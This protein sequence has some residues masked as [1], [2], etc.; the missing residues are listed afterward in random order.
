[1]TRAPAIVA[2][3]GPPGGDLLAFMPDPAQFAMREQRETLGHGLT[4][5]APLTIEHRAY[6]TQ[7]TNLAVFSAQ[8]LAIDQDSGVHS[9]TRFEIEAREPPRTSQ[10]WLVTDEIPWLTTA[11]D[12]DVVVRYTRALAYVNGDG[13]QLQVTVNGWLGYTASQWAGIGVWPT[14]SGSFAALLDKRANAGSS[15]VSVTA[16]GRIG[17]VTSSHITAAV[18]LRGQ[19]EEAAALLMSSLGVT[20]TLGAGPDPRTAFL[21][22]HAAVGEQHAAAAAF[23]RWVLETTEARIV[24]QLD[25][26]FPRD[27][28]R[29][30][31]LLLEEYIDGDDE[32]AII[33]IIRTWSRH[34]DVLHASGRSYFDEFLNALRQSSW[35]RDYGLFT[36]S[37]TSFYTSLFEETEEKAGEITSLIAT[38][39]R[40]FGDYVPAW[41]LEAQGRAP[42]PELTKQT[43]SRVLDA[44]KG[45]TSG[46]DEHLILQTMTGLPGPTQRAVL[47]DIMSRHD[48]RE[49]LVFGKYG[50]AWG[51]GMLYW[52]F[53]ELD[54]DDRAELSKDLVAK[55]VLD[56]NM[57]AVL[58]AGRGWGG[59]W[60]PFTTRKAQ[61]GAQ[62]FA[63]KANEGHWWAY[64]LGVACSLWLPETAGTTVATI[65]AARVLPGVARLHPYVATG[66]L[67]TGTFLSSYE[68]G[69]HAQELATGK[70]PY[71]GR[72]LS[73]EEM[74]QSAL[75]GVSSAL[76]LGAGFASAPGVQ[77]EL[78][79]ARAPRFTL[80]PGFEVGQT[81]LPAFTPRGQSFGTPFGEEGVQYVRHAATGEVFEIRGAAGG[82]RFTVTRLSTGEQVT[83]GRDGAVIP[84]PAGS[85]P[86]N[87]QSIADALAAVTTPPAGGAGTAIVPTTGGA[88]D[89]VGTGP[90][91]GIAPSAPPTGF[92]PYAP[93]TGLAPY[94]PPT[95]LAPFGATTTAVP[96]LVLTPTL[97]PTLA[98]A[99]TPTLTPA[100]DAATLAQI[101]G[102]TPGVIRD[103]AALTDAQVVASL[104]AQLAKV[105]PTN[106]DEL[107]AAFPGR[108]A[109]ARLVLARAS[110]FGPMEAMN[111]L[112]AAIDQHLADGKRLFAP[113][114]GSLADNLAYLSDKAMFEGQPGVNH[115]A[116][117]MV[118]TTTQLENGAIVLLDRVV[119]DMIANDATFA[120]EL[121]S[122]HCVL[123]EPRGLVGGISMF[124]T[125]QAMQLAD[126]TARILARADAIMAGGPIDLEAAI[127]QALAAPTTQVLAAAGVTN[128]VEVVDPGRAAATDS[129][130]IS[131]QVSGRQG[132]TPDELSAALATRPAGERAMIREL[133]AHQGEVFSPRRF[134]EALLAKHQEI[135]ARAAA[136]SIPADKVYFLIPLK[137]KSY[138]MIAMAHR[139][140]TNTPSNRYLNGPEDVKG[141]GPDTMVVIFDDV[142]GSGDSLHQAVA[143]ID[144]GKHPMVFAPTT[145]Y[146][147]H[148]M[149][150]P[151][152]STEA[153][154]ALFAGTGRYGPSGLDAVTG[155]EFRP[156]AMA[157]ALTE[158]VFFRGLD[159][160]QQQTL[161][162][163]VGK[164]GFGQNALSM[165]FPYM[166]PDNNNGLFYELFAR[167]YIM[168][169][170]QKAAKV[171]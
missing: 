12:Y 143:A 105:T 47:Q 44:L 163:I 144:K 146:P 25:V 114:R 96:S 20:A 119:L 127:A 124:N 166:S 5:P 87:A 21:A 58:E 128:P 86:A 9:G 75:L 153:A 150:A 99:L 66:L 35:S 59:K 125:P 81:E 50:E 149:V 30:Q 145:S 6:R 84:G 107:V 131:T 28:A 121:V 1:M 151:M 29:L 61:E 80:P 56:A 45:Y 100:V 132:M 138:G 54:A 65:T 4:M 48:E 3:A 120:A 126:H 111:G 40:A 140:A 133:L 43:A 70:D 52:L 159:A 72:E 51:G 154:A 88:I 137:N 136:M 67:T 38:N 14:D 11:T 93:P 31:G 78:F 139:E 26:D 109:A 98:P 142:G 157:R 92:V 8:A 168:N 155:L 37:S 101:R 95:G 62:F 27:L 17:D 89:P 63:E 41:D 161:S 77:R 36:G 116:A 53:E 115:Q 10:S 34:R 108:E 158:S 57:A 33:E 110:G 90:G 103:A 15:T 94:A 130:T 68:L 171:P 64:P 117:A 122:K 147:G 16:R 129:A 91:P 22:P 19:Y 165:A 106:V 160:T 156:Q 141:L 104:D 82:D 2:A 135:L 113:G 170:N 39:S 112:R 76:F 60:L 46:D 148:V 102:G 42:N 49:Y 73:R 32:R 83:I 71:T 18:T 23:L 13:D 24:A 69:I 74:L 97:T 169:R 55:G 167:F 79:S 162:D 85:L 7:T 123:V 134:A 152:V 118:A 164:K